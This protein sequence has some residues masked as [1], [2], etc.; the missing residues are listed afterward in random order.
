MQSSRICIQNFIIPA[1]LPHSY[2]Y[3]SK[4]A[5]S[6]CCWY[7]VW[8]VAVIMLFG[9]QT[10]L[11]GRLPI[12]GEICAADESFSS[13]TF[14]SNG[15]KL[16]ITFTKM[17]AANRGLR[18]WEVDWR[19]VDSNLPPSRP[20]AVTSPL[21]QYWPIMYHSHSIF[22]ATNG[23]PITCDKLLFYLASFGHHIDTG[24]LAL[25]KVICRQSVSAN[26]GHLKPAI[27]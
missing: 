27:H 18:S 23:K 1:Y 17:A 20:N 19:W 8:L 6:T 7:L 5:T 12:S 24:W 13:F 21:G 26:T 25:Y 4:C 16:D 9:C 14:F 2:V 15:I 22:T 11:P 3:N 10:L